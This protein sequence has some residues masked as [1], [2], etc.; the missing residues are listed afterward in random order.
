VSTAEQTCL[1]NPIVARVDAFGRVRQADLWTQDW[2]GPLDEV[3]F[4]W[5]LNG[6]RPRHSYLE[7]SQ[8]GVPEVAIVGIDPSMAG[9]GAAGFVTC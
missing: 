2:H 8:G 4:Q 3:V 6:R 1:A 5:T 9:P 7:T